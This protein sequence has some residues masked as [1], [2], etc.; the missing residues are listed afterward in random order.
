MALCPFLVLCYVTARVTRWCVRNAEEENAKVRAKGE[1][2]EEKEVGW[3]I[4]IGRRYV[5]SSPEVR[6]R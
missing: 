1:D 3:G 2:V 4:H 5:R 6:Q